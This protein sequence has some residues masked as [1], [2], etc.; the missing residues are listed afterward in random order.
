MKPT[1]VE[2]FAGVGGFRVGLNHAR[3]IEGKTV[4]EPLW[5]TLF[6]NQWEPGSRKQDAFSCY[7][8]RY[9]SRERERE[10]LRNEEEGGGTLFSN[11]DIATVPAE[12]VPEAALLTAGFPCQDYSVAR[13]THEEIGIVGKKGVLWWEIARILRERRMPFLLF[14]NVNRLLLS[15]KKQ[16]GRDFA[17]ILR[18]LAE[19]GY[20][21][22]WRVVNASDY[23]F[24]QRRRR[25]FLLCYHGRTRLAERMREADVISEGI[26]AKALPTEEAKE[27]ALHDLMAFKDLAAVS[28]LFSGPFGNGGYLREGK[29][30]AFELVTRKE[31][32][33]LL[34]DVL[35]HERDERLYLSPSQE[36]K[37]AFLRGAKKIVRKS[38]LG[39]EYLYQEGRMSEYDSAYLPART[40]LTSEGSVNRSSHVV[41][42][43]GNGRLRFL[44]PE[45]CERLNG[46]PAGWTDT[47]MSKGRRY[48]TMGNALVTGIVGRIGDALLPYV[49]EE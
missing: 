4:E 6:M 5:E 23:G 43:P 37:F 9:N 41:K 36:E 49:K 30:H 1:T 2:L 35:F 33:L 40:M 32:P 17:I 11:E 31:E 28:D 19:L 44:S 21:A 10:S 7:L 34:K 25:T 16:R 12:K 8:L 26:L 3:L 14:E 13:K 24:P 29:A 45:E 22:E 27:V 39:E 20:E 48:F 18:T 15:P 42:D 47:G 38:A 46:F